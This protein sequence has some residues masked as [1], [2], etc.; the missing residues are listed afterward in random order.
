ME[1][2]NQLSYFTLLDGIAVGFLLLTWLVLGHVIENPPKSRISTSVIMAD[3]RRKWMVQMITRQPRIFDATVLDTLRQ[4]SA[5]FASASMIAIGGGLAAISNPDRLRGVAQD[6]TI[7]VPEIIWE[8]KILVALIFITSAFLK[9]IWAN[10]LFGYCG[11]VM[12]SVPNEVDA[13][14][15]LPRA[16]KAGELNIAAA[17]AFNRGLR[18][19]Y[20]ALGSLGWFLGPVG[21]IVAILIT[22]FILVRREFTS[23]SRA[24]LLQDET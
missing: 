20:Y 9:F 23:A 7:D 19:I 21:L 8:V 2:L 17:R 13:Q 5:F 3:Y 22:V 12:A 11:V 14:E 15:A 1:L 10:R 24:V 4:N 18:C 6:L 16:K